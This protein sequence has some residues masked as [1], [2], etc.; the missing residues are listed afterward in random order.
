MQF[1]NDQVRVTTEGERTFIIQEARAEAE[2]T[3]LKGAAQ[4]FV[5]EVVGEMETIQ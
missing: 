1:N 2:A 5:V 4:A 3:K